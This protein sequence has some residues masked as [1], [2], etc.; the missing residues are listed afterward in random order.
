MMAVE[1]AA[2]RR[3]T[4]DIS[5]LPRTNEW[6]IVIGDLARISSPRVNTLHQALSILTNATRVRFRRQ[7]ARFVNGADP[8]SHQAAL[9][10]VRRGP[11]S[12]ASAETIS[13]S[14]AAMPTT[15]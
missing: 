10:P 12:D 11:T 1:N 3:A 15:P 8:N 13:G 7:F 14:V 9:E 2:N 4:K 6:S 5:F